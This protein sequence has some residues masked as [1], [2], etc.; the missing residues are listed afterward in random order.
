MQWLNAVFRYSIV[1]LLACVGASAALHRP[2]PHAPG[3]NPY[4]SFLPA[5]AKTDHAYWR[6]R[7]HERARA[8]NALRTTPD[9]TIAVTENEPN[10]TAATANMIVGFGTGE[11]LDPAADITGSF[12][13]SWPPV[14]IGPFAEDEGS[15]PLASDTGLVA[16]ASVRVSGTIGDGPY[17]SAGT[18][19]GDVDFFRIANV[20]VGQ[21]IVI[22]VETALPF[23][24]LDTFIGLYDGDGNS[25][26]LNEDED[27]S[28]T[29]DSFLAIP[30]PVAGDYYV[31]IAGSLFP[32]A[33]ILADPFDASSGFGV[34]S[35]GDYEVILRL[36]DGDPD[37]FTL[38]LEAC[39]ILGVNLMD[40]GRQVLLLDPAG[41]L[42]VASSQD[43][44]GAYPDASLLP[45]GGRAVFGFVASTPGTYALRALGTSGAY[46]MA[47]RV[48]RPPSEPAAE[49][50]TLFVDFDGATVDPAIFG[51]T[52]GSATLSP[53]A[54]FLPAWG[55]APGDENAAIDAILATL[56]ENLIDDP[57]TSG[58]RGNIGI[59]LLN[60]RDHADP[61]GAP[62]VS[63]LIIGGTIAELGLPTI[64]I[65]QSIDP[66]NF[67]GAETGVILLDLLSRSSG[68]PNSL[69][70]FPRAPGVSMVD[71]LGVAIGNIAAH[72]A[73][74]Y[75]GNFH[76]E[77]FDPL[78]NIMDRGGNL[79][80]TIGLGP[81]GIFGSDDDVDV[82]FGVNLYEPSERFAGQEDTLAVTACG[83][84]LNRLFADDF[85]TGDLSR[86]SSIVP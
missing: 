41:E 80:N 79:P 18:G 29:R 65:A 9:R 63:R 53:F 35:E 82:D 67:E 5:G 50:K 16:G 84:A 38:D 13:P 11:G 30:A 10:N 55:L 42:V 39:D 32:F 44:S 75:V 36:E 85:E 72:E 64:G 59:R 51:Q 14:P 81:D 27:A 22:D 70:S 57:S 45:G 40:A 15:I 24:D 71:L 69:N 23:D 31:S 19:S 12:A 77:Q 47:L 86:W 7:M 1:V 58:P 37:W 74:H 62:N 33:S 66:G 28:V 83:C 78:A 60:S 76:T 46:T 34:G 2:A 68:D 21:L 17:G 3:P 73:G 56:H 49:P 8:R 52:P 54:N 4:L 43:L 26:A 6:D 48:F 20:A 61:F 25:V